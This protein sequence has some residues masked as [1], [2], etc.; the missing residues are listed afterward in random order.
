MGN[1]AKAKADGTMKHRLIQNQQIN[2]VK[3]AVALTE[4][5][6]LPR[7]IDHAR[8]V[9][10]L[11]EDLRPGEVVS[12][13]ILDFKDA[14][15]SIPLHP[16]EMRFNCAEVV[17][18][19]NRSR[20]EIIEGEAASGNCLVWRVLGFGAVPTPFCCTRAPLRSPC[21]RRKQCWISHLGASRGNF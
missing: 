17:E 11:I 1:I 21:G 20:G 4:R 10:L 5:Q 3:S 8:D 16:A 13:F 15:M 2:C 19:L 14:F 12:V 6:V 7:P 18:T 9:G